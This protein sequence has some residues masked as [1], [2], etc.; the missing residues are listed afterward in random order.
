MFVDFVDER[1][2]FL[3]RFFVGVAE[4]RVDEFSNHYCGVGL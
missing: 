3:E 2:D 1:G 4:D